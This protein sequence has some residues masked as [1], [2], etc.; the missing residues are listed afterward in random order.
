[1]GNHNL[2]IKI[3]LK[4]TGFVVMKKALMFLLF[5]V[6]P[7]A[8]QNIN[9]QR[10]QLFEGKYVETTYVM[11]FLGKNVSDGLESKV[12]KDTC[13]ILIKIDTQ[14][15]ETWYLRSESF[16]GSTPDSTTGYTG[17]GWQTIDSYKRDSLSV[18]IADIVARQ[19][20]KDT[21]SKP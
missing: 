6:M 14:T 3:N 12:N 15:G 7:L 4:N 8:A 11:K 2:K 16:Q 19:I 20:L 18:K 13:L 21:P 9:A 5:F 10:F 1:L 17:F